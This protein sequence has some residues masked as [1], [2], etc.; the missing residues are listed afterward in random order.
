MTVTTHGVARAGCFVSPQCSEA[1]YWSTPE[2][3]RHFDRGHPTWH[4]TYNFSCAQFQ[5]C[6]DHDHTDPRRWM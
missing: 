2:G 4:H 3:G 5:N 6:G 1:L